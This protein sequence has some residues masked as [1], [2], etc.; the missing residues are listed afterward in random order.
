ML[1][2]GCGQEGWKLGGG[3]LWNILTTQKKMF[4]PPLCLGLRLGLWKDWSEGLL[5]TE[6]QHV[7]QHFIPN[8]G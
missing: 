5:Q 2:L 8:V 3:T 6:S 1:K 7:L 4:V